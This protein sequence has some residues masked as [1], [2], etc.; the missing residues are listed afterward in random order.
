M[1]KETRRVPLPLPRLAAL[2]AAGALVQGP[3]DAQEADAPVADGR[4]LVSVKE[5]MEKTI[6]PVTNTLWSAYE[7]PETDDEWLRLEE[8]A[9]TLLVAANVLALGGTGPMDDEWANAPAW[10]AYN[11]AMTTAAN[12][13]LVA[14]RGRDLDALLAAGDALL[15]PCEGCHRDFNPGVAGAQ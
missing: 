4:P 7:P 6:T 8:A 12:D 11:Q 10:R 9:V 13:A 1:P 15:P 2:L 3:L 5:L 14:A